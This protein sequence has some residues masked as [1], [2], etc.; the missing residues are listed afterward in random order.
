MKIF[1]F[2]GKLFA[3]IGVAVVALFFVLLVAGLSMSDSK[4][5]VSSNTVLEM[6]FS[7]GV[8]EYRPDEPFM[9]FFD[10]LGESKPTLQSQV[11]VLQQAA[12]DDR[13]VGIVAN[14]S[15][16]KMGIAQMQEL[17]DALLQFRESGKF[18]VA[19][20]D[21]FPGNGAYYMATAFDKI[22]LQPSGDLNLIGIG[23]DSMFLKGTLDKLGI[24]PRMAQRYEYKNAMNMFTETE[25][26]EAHR[27]AME[28]L[29]GSIFDQMVDD[30]S[31]ARKL[32]VDQINAL[33]DKGPYLGV[34]ALEAKLIDGLQ[35]RDEV[36][37]GLEELNGEDINLLYPGTYMGSTE[38]LLPE[39]GKD[40][41]A[42]IYGVGEVKRGA[43]E[44]NPMN[45]S[46]VMGS[47]SVTSAF[48]KALKDDDVKAI[49]FRVDSPGGSYVASDSIWRETIH[50]KEKGIPIIVSMGNLAASGGYFVAMNADKIVAQPG[51]ITGSIGV[52][53]GKFITTA[54]WEK[55]GVS[56]DGLQTHERSRMYS[57]VQDFSDEEWTRY[58]DFLDRIYD[59]F[60]TKAAKGRNMPLEKLQALAKGRV[61]TGRDALERGLVDALGGV[62]KAVEL[63]KE[64]A[65][66][67]ADTDISLQRYPEKKSPWD[68]FKQPV[69]SEGET[70]R[71]FIISWL[72][73]NQFLMNILFRI[74]DPQT[75]MVELRAP[76]ADMM[77]TSEGY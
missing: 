57:S 42:L 63:A 28:V 31:K 5:D 18:A 45:D 4:V 34:E 40:K 2:L 71:S 55:L 73:R 38:D 60:T 29:L 35:Y 49:V 77:I 76:V 47:S 39:T 36:Y 13:V 48:R 26:T 14:L 46:F 72:H 30:I 10:I 12:K 6:N 21:T 25:F 62:N 44:Y 65:G 1:K 3:F 50:A 64:A 68:M 56:W 15:S 67:P 7:G 11:K 16:I 69:N 33:I 74:S 9:E 17:R 75:E 22:Y 41:I 58:N 52:L 27:E 32:S 43:S 54:F 53:G 19:Y 8:L 23:Y 61:W 51:T 59:D 20:A 66:I 24:V 70:T 37:T